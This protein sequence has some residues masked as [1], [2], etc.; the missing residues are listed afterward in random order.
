MQVERLKMKDFKAFKDLEIQI[1]IRPSLVVLCGENGSGKSS[2]NDAMATWRNH[3]H[4][5]YGGDPDFFK[6]GG[7]RGESAAGEVTIDFHQDHVADRRAAVYVRTAQRITV[8]F[9]NPGLQQLPSP[10][11]E[12]GPPRSIDLDDRIAQDYQR[13]ITLSVDAVWDEERRSR[14]SGEFIDGV[15]GAI[16]EPLARLI[17][18]RP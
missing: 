5:G 12:Q 7:D 14:P 13:L 9:T 16:A 3:Q 10:I 8:E 11:D 15:V 6:R 1:P 2:V 17:P 18:G 4:W